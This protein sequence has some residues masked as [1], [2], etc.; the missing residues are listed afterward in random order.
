[1][2]KGPVIFCDTDGGELGKQSAIDYIR[3]YGFTR[4]DVSLTQNTG[5][6][7]V[8]AKR[9]VRVKLGIDSTN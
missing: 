6:T 7:L 8:I 5:M 4:D 9:D 2:G 1:M 3:R